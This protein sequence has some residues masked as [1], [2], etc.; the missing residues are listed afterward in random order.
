MPLLHDGHAIGQEPFVEPRRY[1]MDQ[2]ERTDLDMDRLGPGRA[3]PQD[4]GGREEPGQCAAPGD[5][6]LGCHVPACR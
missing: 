5:R 4:R 3:Q 6:T 2:L 1:R